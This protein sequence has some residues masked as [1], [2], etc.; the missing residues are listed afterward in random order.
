M[1]EQ[2]DWRDERALQLAAAE[3]ERVRHHPLHG[4]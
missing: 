1:R 4:P 2:R 3:A